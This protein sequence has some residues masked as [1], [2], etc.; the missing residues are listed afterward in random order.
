MASKILFFFFLRDFSVFFG[1]KI[2]HFSKKI[3]KNLH[4]NNLKKVLLFDITINLVQNDINF[5]G[6]VDDGLEHNDSQKNV[7]GESNE[8]KIEDKMD[9]DQ[10][11]LK[12]RIKNFF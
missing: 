1:K 10:R 2:A 11:F 5:I 12:F 4:F 6:L 3:F 8:N 7:G 9:V